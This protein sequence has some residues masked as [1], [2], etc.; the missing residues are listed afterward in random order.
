MAVSTGPIKFTTA[1]SITGWVN[2]DNLLSGSSG[3]ASADT[4]SGTK[5]FQLRNPDSAILDTIPSNATIV[6]VEILTK[7]K[8]DGGSE[9]LQI[10]A[11]IGTKHGD[12]PTPTISSTT[13]QT[14]VTGG[15]NDLY[16]LEEDI[17]SPSDL[18]NFRIRYRVQ[19]AT[20]TLSLTGDTEAPTVTFHYTLPISSSADTGF[21]RFKD[22]ADVNFPMVNLDALKSGGNGSATTSDNA[23]KLIFDLLASSDTAKDDLGIPEGSII[24]GI[25]FK[26]RA[27]YAG[28]GTAPTFTSG[29]ESNG[30]ES[31][32]SSPIT[33]TDSFVDY[34]IGGDNELF[35]RRI[36][37]ELIVDARQILEFINPDGLEI[38][39]EGSE[40]NAT[41]SYKVYY[42][43]PPLTT[44]NTGWVKFGTNEEDSNN[45]ASGT[46]SNRL[47]SGEVGELYFLS[48]DEVYFILKNPDSFNVPSGAT[49]T[50][51]QFRGEFKMSLP[52]TINGKLSLSDFSDSDITDNFFSLTTDLDPNSTNAP[53]ITGSYDNLFGLTPSPSDLSDLHLGIKIPTAGGSFG[54]ITGTTESPAIKIF[55]IPPSPE[56][57]FVLPPVRSSGMYVRES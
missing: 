46:P 28:G 40:S 35:G 56:R 54:I 43:P 1:T 53:Y 29:F 13:N 6:G 36:N 23:G 16:G 47:L 50:G 11:S 5:R 33:L 44:L 26:I 45:W 42:D 27:K 19:N 52:A 49:I 20:N 15:P 22:V 3:D 51:I 9:N 39:I 38:T 18:S 10:R 32:K 8:V 12:T 25:E 57:S 37:E 21:K 4:G 31:F 30:K 17:S 55:Y 14:I 34:T 24:R 2:T 48:S 7:T 41:P